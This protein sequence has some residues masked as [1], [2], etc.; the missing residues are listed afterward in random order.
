MNHAAARE[1][2]GLL[3]SHPR[4]TCPHCHKPRHAMKC[5]EQLAYENHATW[6]LNEARATEDRETAHRDDNER[7][8][9]SNGAVDWEN[10]R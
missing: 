1:M 5:K 7:D 4:E 6:E 10:A 8:G 3:Y 2:F 9:A